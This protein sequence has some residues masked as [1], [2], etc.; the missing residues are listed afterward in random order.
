MVWKFKCLPYSERAFHC[1]G[2]TIWQLP[3]IFF[4]THFYF[5]SKQLIAVIRFDLKY[6]REKVTILQDIKLT[7]KSSSNSYYYSPQTNW[8]C[9]A[10]KRYM[11]M[12]KWRFPCI[13]VNQE[14]WQKV[15]LI[16]KTN[17]ITN[18]KKNHF[19]RMPNAGWQRLAKAI[20]IFEGGEN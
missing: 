17:V 14:R 12:M 5:D 19:I 7:L 13:W 15:N 4:D 11:A 2:K 1:N 10:C 9:Y 20:S 8:N 3:F 16:K 18:R 6:E